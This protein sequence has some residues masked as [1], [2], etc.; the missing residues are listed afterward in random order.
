RGTARVVSNQPTNSARAFA[1]GADIDPSFDYPLPIAGWNILNFNFL[2][3]N[4]QLA[5][6]FGGVIAVGNIQRPHLWGDKVDGSVDFFGLALKA[7]DAIFDAAGERRGERV[8]TIPAAAGATIGYQ[9]TPFHKITARYDFKF[10]AYFAD[11]TQSV[12]FVTPSSTVT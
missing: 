11:S 10:D 6:L 7:N 9:I 1:M 12:G 5:L 3:R 8:Q 4:M 2:N